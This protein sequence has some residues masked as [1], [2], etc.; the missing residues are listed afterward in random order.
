MA[1]KCSPSLNT[2]L[3]KA[4]VSERPPAMRYRLELLIL[5]IV[6]A[7]CSRSSE[8]EPNP[9][10][11]DSK[12][13]EI[14]VTSEPLLDMTMATVRDAADVRRIVPAST[15]SRDWK[16]TSEEAGLMQQA[17]LILI[18]GAGYEPWKDRVS[19]PGSRIRDTAAGYYDQFI[20]IPDAVSHQHGPDGPHSHPGT[21][22]ATWLAPELCVA[23][24]HQVSIQCGRLLPDQKQT[25]ETAEAR[26]AAEFNSLNSEIASI[27]ERVSEKTGN[28]DLTVFS[29]APH[30]QYLARRLGWK[31]HYLHWSDSETLSDKDRESLLEAFKLNGDE[32]KI[33]LMNSR[34]SSSAEAYV[35]ESGGTVI[36]I[37][38]C[39]FASPDGTPLVAR[40]KQNLQH[41]R[42][43]F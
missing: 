21:V 24:L 32:R 20:R 1:R 37:D 14:I 40:L 18:S 3:R 36:R 4:I 33:F 28:A 25:I 10:A 42:D 41:I 31:L 16:P 27:Q 15:T 38:L 34:R 11:A 30:Y 7:G 5:L 26:L 9:A 23:Q 19:L 17:N 39:E 2:G 35:R 8:P 12:R 6:I 43:A 22:W 29:D 13:P